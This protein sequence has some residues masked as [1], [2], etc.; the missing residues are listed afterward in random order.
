VLEALCGWTTVSRQVLSPPTET[1]PHVDGDRFVAVACYRLR[2]K[3]SSAGSRPATKPHPI[4][5]FVA[6]VAQLR[7]GSWARRSSKARRSRCVI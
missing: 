1:G 4:P 5:R 6:G 3:H 7:R 2:W